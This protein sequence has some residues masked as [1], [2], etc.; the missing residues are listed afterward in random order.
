MTAILDLPLELIEQI[1]FAHERLIEAKHENGV[2]VA[3]E[4]GRSRL[5]CRYFE[6]ATRCGFVEKNFVVWIVKAPDEENI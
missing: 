1:H 4:L 2:G 5:S 3:E 6:H